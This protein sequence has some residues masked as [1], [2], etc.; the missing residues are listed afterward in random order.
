MHVLS[1]LCHGFHHWFSFPVADGFSLLLTILLV[2]KN[3]CYGV[4]ISSP[5]HACSAY[6]PRPHLFVGLY[7]GYNYLASAEW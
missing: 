3:N 1:R 5:T 2:A 6:E 7:V 4:H